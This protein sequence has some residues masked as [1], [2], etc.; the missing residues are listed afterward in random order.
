MSSNVFVL[1]K[2]VVKISIHLNS[3]KWCTTLLPSTLLQNYTVYLDCYCIVFTVKCSVLFWLGLEV[4][5]PFTMHS[6]FQIIS[7]KWPET[8]SFRAVSSGKTHTLTHSNTKTGRNSECE[9]LC[10]IHTVQCISCNISLTAGKMKAVSLVLNPNH[11]Q[12][13]YVM[14]GY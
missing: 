1:V 5:L 13:L 7:K 6:P 2:N 10:G 4:N 3:F 14:A 8:V 12:T 11:A 9:L